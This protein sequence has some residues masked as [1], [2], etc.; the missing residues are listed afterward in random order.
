[1]GLRVLEEL[2]RSGKS[3]PVYESLSQIHESENGADLHW[4][5]Q[6]GSISRW[7]VGRMPQITSPNS[8]DTCAV[9]GL[10]LRRTAVVGTAADDS[11]STLPFVAPRQPVMCPWRW[12]GV[13]WKASLQPQAWARTVCWVLVGGHRGQTCGTKIRIWGV[14]PL[15]VYFLLKACRLFL[16]TTSIATNTPDT[17]WVYLFTCLT[18]HL[19]EMLLT[20]DAV[21]KAHMG[22]V[23]ISQAVW[24][25]EQCW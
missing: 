3:V 17:L 21:E 24:S 16:I 10:W 14:F 2:I 18:C 20:R 7:N 5:A 22:D 6:F 25:G 23:F 4:R 8:G 9:L 11:L 1:M 13:L 12:M 15:C 19:V